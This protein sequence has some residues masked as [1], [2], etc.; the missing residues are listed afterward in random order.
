MQLSTEFVV[1]FAKQQPSDGLDR[2]TLR[3]LK[4]SPEH[5]LAP[6]P[7]IVDLL[8]D[9]ALQHL[10]KQRHS[11]HPRDFLFPHDFDE[12]M[13]IES[14]RVTNSCAGIQHTQQ[15]NGQLEQ[16]V[17]RQNGKI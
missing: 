3:Y 6:R 10:E 14:I 9:A 5:A 12:F 7:R 15:P 8:F 11:D 4:D 1:Y 17:E 13:R 2:D 16:M